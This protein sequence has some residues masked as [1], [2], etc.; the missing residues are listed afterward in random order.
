MEMKKGDSRMDVAALTGSDSNYFDNQEYVFIRP[1]STN[2]TPHSLPPLSENLLKPP[3]TPSLRNNNNNNNNMPEQEQ[4]L[5][6][7][8]AT[9]ERTQPGPPK[10]PLTY[11]CICTHGLP[12][13]FQNPPTWS[14]VCRVAMY[15][16]ELGY[17]DRKYF[18]IRKEIC[19]FIEAHYDV[20]VP[21]T[22][23]I[24]WRQTVNMTLSHPQ[25][26]HIFMQESQ[27]HE[28]GRRKG[29]LPGYYC[30]RQRIDLYKLPEPEKKTRRKRYFDEANTKK[31][32]FQNENDD[33]TSTTT[34]TSSHFNNFRL[35]NYSTTTTTTTTTTTD[36][37]DFRSSTDESSGEN[38]SEKGP[39]KKG[40]IKKL[41]T[42]LFL[43]FLERKSLPNSDEESLGD[44]ATLPPLTSLSPESTTPTPTPLPPIPS[45]TSPT[46]KGTIPSSNGTPCLPPLS[47]LP[48][49]SSASKL[50]ATSTQL[51][52]P[53]PVP[54][55]TAIS[56]TQLIN[57][58]EPH[59]DHSLFAQWQAQPSQGGKLDNSSIVNWNV[60]REPRSPPHEPIS[61]SSFH[62]PLISHKP[63]HPFPGKFDTDPQ[64]HE[65][66]SQQFTPSSTFSNT[67][68]R[69]PSPVLNRPPHYAGGIPFPPP[70]PP[71]PHLS[72]LKR[73]S[74]PVSWQ[75]EQPSS[76]SSYHQYSPPQYP[77]YSSQYPPHSS[78]NFTSSPYQKNPLPHPHEQPLPNPFAQANTTPTIQI[79][80]SP[81]QQK[82]LPQKGQVSPASISSSPPSPTSSSQKL[83][84]SGSSIQTQQPQRRNRLTTRPWER[85]ILEDYYVSFFCQSR[86]SRREKVKVDELVKKLG[87]EISRIQR[88]LDNRRTKDRPRFGHPE[89][90]SA[91]GEEESEGEETSKSAKKTRRTEAPS[92]SSPNPRVYY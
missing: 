9:L 1:P 64:S 49:F 51:S 24:S 23:S 44:S 37:I 18:H 34:S 30:L 27:D 55:K 33:E 50:P 67:P 26:S 8:G 32:G 13:S 61:N 73:S 11:C 89:F 72:S 58:D 31:K 5:D 56:V 77:S 47:A 78:F 42:D 82:Q 68:G 83:S 45:L 71:P 81:L 21:K 54:S 41:E 22:K 12:P 2:E 10:C 57:N 3:A 85:A 25:Y 20:L 88:W 35:D 69:P 53:P 59:T 17:Q 92:P 80:Q 60:K 91:K 38:D 86:H 36:P 52:S 6:E 62:S 43:Y 79:H 87:W 75:Y 48:H 63:Q 16:L 28:Y 15:A 19:P 76:Q 4:E 74:S 66:H 7:N 84:S 46:S 40:L 70:P 90:G 29:A 39:N 14:E 65:Y